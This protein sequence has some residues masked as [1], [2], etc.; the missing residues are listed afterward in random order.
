MLRVE[1][2]VEVYFH[3]PNRGSLDAGEPELFPLDTFLEQVG[4]T[5]YKS[6]DH[7]TER[8]APKFVEMLS[9]RGH[10]AMLE[11]CVAS[12]KFICDRGV[13]H[14]LVRH[15]LASFA[16]ESTRYCNYSKDKFGSQI[17]AIVPPFTKV[18]SE[19]IW[20]ETVRIIEDAYRRLIDNGEPPQLARSVLPISVKTEIWCTANLREWQHI[21]NM[22]CAPTAHPQIRE[23]MLQTLEVFAVEVPPMFQELWVE[24]GEENP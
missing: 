10:G 21:F 4:R 16:Q 22:R 20:D 3:Y 5:C 6:E 24:F 18:G 1:P 7:I 23:L 17:S 13:T 11:H 19:Q 8:S 2:S 9:K 15:R 14:E 12:V